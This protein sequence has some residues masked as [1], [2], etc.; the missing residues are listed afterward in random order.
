MFLSHISL[1]FSLCVP[2]SL[3]KKS[4]DISLSEDLKRRRRGGGGGGAGGGGLAGIG[5]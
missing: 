1:S 5:C 2:S 4:A 3:S